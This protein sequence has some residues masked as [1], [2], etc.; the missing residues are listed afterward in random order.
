MLSNVCIM[1]TFSFSLSITVL[2]P[3]KKVNREKRTGIFG[4]AGAARTPKYTPLHSSMVVF[5]VH[6]VLNWMKL[7]K[8]S[9]V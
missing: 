3:L 7:R 2:T 5:S 6:S 1:Y 4:G 9:E 8:T